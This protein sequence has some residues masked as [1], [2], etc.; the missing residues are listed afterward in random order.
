MKV[1]GI[2]FGRKNKNCDIL[3]KQA[4]FAAQEAGAEVKFINTMNMKI[5]HCTGCGAC[6]KLRDQGKQ[7]KCVAIKDD[8]LEL[9]NEILNADGII[10]GAPVYSIAP[11][12]QLKNYIDRFG[13]AH[14]RAAA[15][16]EQDKRIKAG[17]E[18]LLDPRV[19]ADKYVA[20]ISVG[21]AKTPDWVSMGLPNM[22]MFGMSTVMKTVGQIDAYNMG[23]AVSPILEDELME[24]TAKLGKHLA[25][26]IGKPY[27]Q[28][29]WLG[30]EGVCPVCHNSIITIGK[31]TEV[32]CPLCGIHGNLSIEDGEV[33]VTFSEKEQNRA[34][35]TLEGLTEH[36]HEIQG[37]I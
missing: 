20:Y 6:S 11:T 29:E 23:T 36:Y 14:D 12:G 1:L 2:S 24:Q 7:I 18:E 16:A 9:E 35:N 32:L 19:L 26:S 31:T 3:V 22:H 5:S 37:F 28:V 27:D 10:V 4:L 34:R 25:E 30:E 13:A 33:K 21:G 17:A 15:L 8:Y